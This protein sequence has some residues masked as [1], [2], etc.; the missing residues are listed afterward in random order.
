MLLD[1]VCVL[2]LLLSA[3][4]HVVNNH[5]RAA[6][7]GYRHGLQGTVI[8]LVQLLLIGLIFLTYLGLRL[9]LA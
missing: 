4:L 1:V 8:V 9:L 5:S 7:E 6:R 2:L 3:V